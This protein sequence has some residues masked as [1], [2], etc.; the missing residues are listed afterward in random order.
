MSEVAFDDNGPLLVLELARNS[1]L[2]RNTTGALI[3]VNPDGSPETLA[4]EWSAGNSQ[5]D[6][7]NEGMRDLS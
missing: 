3:R 4:R 7:L 6:Q 2:S 1:L 5:C